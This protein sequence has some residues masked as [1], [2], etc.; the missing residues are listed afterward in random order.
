MEV[1]NQQRQEPVQHTAHEEVHP[2]ASIEAPSFRE[3]SDFWVLGI[4]PIIAMFFAYK[5]LKLKVEARNRRRQANIKQK[6]HDG[7]MDEIDWDEAGDETIMS[8]VATKLRKK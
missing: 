2:T 4:V 5:S 1:K 6:I 8:Y 7:E 3:F